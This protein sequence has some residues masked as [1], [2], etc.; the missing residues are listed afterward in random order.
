MDIRHRSDI[1]GAR[2]RECELRTGEPRVRTGEE[3]RDSREVLEHGEVER[4]DVEALCRWV[5]TQ[6]SHAVAEWS[7]TPKVGLRPASYDVIG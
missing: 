2:E 3:G 1:G 6:S 4:R 7:S 5:I